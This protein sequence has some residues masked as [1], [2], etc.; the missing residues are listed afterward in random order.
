MAYSVVNGLK[1]YMKGGLK[2]INLTFFQINL[3]F[4]FKVDFRINLIF[5]LLVLT[6]QNFPSC[7]TKRRNKFFLPFLNMAF[8]VVLT[9]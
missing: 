9:H 4:A 6:K 7:V 8:G 1:T 3:T 2:I 5:S